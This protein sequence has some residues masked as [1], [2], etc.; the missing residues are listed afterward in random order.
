MTNK[1]YVSSIVAFIFIVVLSAFPV[2]LAIVF[3]LISK[4]T[5]ESYKQKIGT[6]FN[7]LRGNTDGK[8]S[9]TSLM[10]NSIFMLRRVIIVLSA[11]I[12]SKWPFA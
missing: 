5:L 7:E 3:Y 4:E 9:R 10:F 2:I 1:D 6:L 12:M 11:S 8:L